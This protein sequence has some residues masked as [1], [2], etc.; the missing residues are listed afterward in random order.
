MRIH[1]ILIALGTALIP[2]CGLAAQDGGAVAPPA[3]DPS[4]TLAAADVFILADAAR[5]QGD[6]AFAEAAYTALTNDPDL[7]MRTE[8]R[9]R[10]ARMYADLMNRPRDA[11]VLLRRILDDK[12]DE[13][14]IRIELARVQ[15]MMGN[16]AAAERELRAV[17]AGE[18]PPQVQ[19][20]I[21]FYASALASGKPSGGSSPAETARSSRSAAA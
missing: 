20:M 2:V 12:P 4:S 8:A 16:Y 10:L 1:A 13:P 15:A 5:D 19:Q 6:H 17:S 9:F 7:E 21:R 18:L 3:A 11:A 14:S